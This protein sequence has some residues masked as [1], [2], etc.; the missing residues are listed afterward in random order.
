MS[1]ITSFFNAVRRFAYDFFVSETHGHYIVINAGD[2][3][4]LYTVGFAGDYNNL[5]TVGFAGDY[6]T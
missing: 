6:A 5:Y 2:Y 4:N 3:N 1:S